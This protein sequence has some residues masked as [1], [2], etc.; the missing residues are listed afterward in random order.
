MDTIVVYQSKTGFTERYARWIS[1]EMQCECMDGEH[2]SPAALKNCSR[3]LY[4]GGVYA[5][6]IAGL[7]RF[8][9]QYAGKLTVLAVGATPVQAQQV[10]DGYWRA[11]FTP[12]ECVQIPHFYLQG[13][14]DYKKIGFFSRA[15]LRFLSGSLRRKKDLSP[16]DAAMAQ[17]LAGSFDATDRALIAPI[18]EHLRRPNE[19]PLSKQ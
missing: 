15:L 8:R 12:D 11:N 13:G 17:T 19:I 9:R 10:I 2:L 7:K 6:Q 1:E 4:C 18:V 14:L 16:S 5:G 3:V